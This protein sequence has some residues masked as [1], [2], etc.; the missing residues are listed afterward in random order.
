MVSFHLSKIFPAEL[1]FWT[2]EYPKNEVL[3]RLMHIRVPKY[4]IT[5]RKGC[6]EKFS[7]F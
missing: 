4:N 2:G 6:K 3:G 5:Q 1:R 7:Y